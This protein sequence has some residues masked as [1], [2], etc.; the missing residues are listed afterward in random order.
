MRCS[1]ETRQCEAVTVE[2]G[3]K[4]TRLSR[5]GAAFP[6]VAANEAVIAAARCPDERPDPEKIAERIARPRYGLF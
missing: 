2:S 1:T 6:I 4:S 5:R 3:R